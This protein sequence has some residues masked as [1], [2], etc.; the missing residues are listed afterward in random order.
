MPPGDD[1]D[2]LAWMLFQQ[3]GVISQRQA[4][5][6]LSAKTIRH[7]VTSGRWQRPHRG[8]LVAHA[9][10]LTAEQ[11]TWVA[12]LAVAA[13]KHAYLGG[14]S[15]LQTYG[16]RLTSDVIHVLVPHGQNDEAPPAGVRVHRTRH[17]PGIDL[18]GVG[19]P[20]R[21]MPPRSVVDAATWAR[22]DD[23]AR[24]IIV[25]AIQRRVVT[26]DEILAVLAR[27]PRAR[28]RVLIATTALDADG[29]AQSLGELDFLEL[30]RK[31]G[32]PQPT[33]QVVR[34]DAAG[35]RRILDAYFAPWGVHVE[36]DGGHHMD[37]E[38]WWLDLRRQN[39][40]WTAGDRILRFPA[41][42][43][44]A[45]PDEVIAQLRAALVAAGWR[46]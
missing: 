24:L 39:D 34:K 6:L 18:H 37:A 3:Q 8:I 19:L 23:E 33:R 11:R 26:C 40:L 42:V 27:L 14:L 32:L 36:I 28:R 4:L 12:V 17:L 31:G 29:G 30:C 15:A 16:V 20:P 7:K 13:G 25:V 2:D 9:A 46:P 35:R 43:V 38:Q 5:S 1:A 22:S 21:T 41:W 45:R 10:P 44:R